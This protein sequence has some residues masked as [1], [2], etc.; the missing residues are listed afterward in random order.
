MQLGCNLVYTIYL[1]KIFTLPFTRITPIVSKTLWSVCIVCG[2]SLIN[3]VAWYSTCMTTVLIFEWAFCDCAWRSR[4]EGRVCVVLREFFVTLPRGP[5][6]TLHLVKYLCRIHGWS[7]AMSRYH[8]WDQ[9][10]VHQLLNLKL[11]E[12]P[13]IMMSTNWD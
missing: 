1:W 13:S 2:L 6:K 3:G 8:Q 10:F 5:E 9:T 7:V 4:W 11:L 12:T